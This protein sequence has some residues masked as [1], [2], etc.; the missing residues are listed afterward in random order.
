MLLLWRW[1]TSGSFV[2]G[3]G[4]MTEESNAMDI[5]PEGKL[6][7]EQIE[8]IKAFHVLFSELAYKLVK[9]EMKWTPFVRMLREGWLEITKKRE[10]SFV[11]RWFGR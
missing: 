6:T 9:G 8:Q 10:E 3:R 1:L 7:P 11:G 5:S 4:K 2:Y